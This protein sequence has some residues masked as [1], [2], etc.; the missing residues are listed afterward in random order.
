MGRYWLRDYVA[1]GVRNWQ[2]S[3][4][5]AAAVELRGWK[6]HWQSPRRHLQRRRRAAVES[7]VIRA[8]AW[9]RLL[10]SGLCAFAFGIALIFAVAMLDDIVSDFT[11]SPMRSPTWHADSQPRQRP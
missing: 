9:A 11:H 8:L 10:A 7:A 5:A 3:I 2:D 1:G 4:A 6:W